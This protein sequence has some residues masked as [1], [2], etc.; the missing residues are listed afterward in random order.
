MSSQQG[1]ATIEAQGLSKYYG[2]FAAVK[3]VSFQV[4]QGEVVAFLGPNGAGKSTTMKLLTGYLA[5][6]AGTARIA[7][8]DMAA[9]RVAGSARLGYLP[10]NGP[11]YPDMTPRSLL[12][13]FADARGLSSQHKRER[14]DAV[15]ELCGL[16]SV[17]GK[18][19]AKLSRGYRQ[20]VGMA[21]VLLHEPD[22]L[23][24]DEPTAGLD[25]NQIHDVR[26]TIRKLGQRK[27][28]LL[29]THILQEVEAMA[30]RVL[31]IDEGRLVFDGPIAELTRGKRLDE[32]FREMSTAVA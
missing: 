31:F 19:I 21:Q 18:P 30:R 17:I 4:C 13:F 8:H 28:I 6:S 27:T 14:I 16:G 20:R 7:G 9:D 12:R 25:P 26:E 15:V 22:V 2:D 1:A 5:P 3:D 29:S 32:R 10:E 23:I 24:L 11:L